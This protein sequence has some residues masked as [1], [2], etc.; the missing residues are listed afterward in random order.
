MDD[1]MSEP[2]LGLGDDQNENEVEV[3]AVDMPKKAGKRKK[4]D[5]AAGKGKANQKRTRAKR[6]KCWKYFKEVNAVSKKRS[7]ERRVGKEC[8]L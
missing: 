6:S 5:V 3:S 7:E 1:E 2:F 8:L 4:A